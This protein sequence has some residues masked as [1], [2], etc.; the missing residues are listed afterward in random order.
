VITTGFAERTYREEA[1]PHGLTSFRVTVGQTDLWIA[2]ESD[3]TDEAYRSVRKHRSALEDYIAVHPGFAESLKPVKTSADTEGLVLVMTE[4]GNRV[5]I[6]P[7]SA[8]AGA[9]SE[10]VS[11]ELARFSNTVMVENGGDL[12]LMGGG[13]R[14]I[15]IWAGNSPLSGRVGILIKSDTGMAVCTSSGTVGPSLSF[16]R[17]DAATVISRSGALADAAATDLGNRVKSKEDIEPALDVTLNIEGI[18]G[19]AVIIGDAVGAMG[20]VELVK[21]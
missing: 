19:A 16:G 13:S 1:A 20:E 12:Y 10:A 3:L 11:R 8:V 7:M 15:G 5:G 6:G 18:L 21:I 9:I 17:A 14:K 2:A 4:A